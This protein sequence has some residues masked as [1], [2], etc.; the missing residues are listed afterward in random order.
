MTG[1][2]T[3]AL[4][5]TL[6]GLGA[7]SEVSAGGS[8]TDSS[9]ALV[10]P[11][12][13]RPTTVPAVVPAAT[14]TSPDTTVAAPPSPKSAVATTSTSSTTTSVL[15]G[16]DEPSGA[17]T[18]CTHVAYIGDSISLGM[19]S[20]ETLPNATARLDAQMAAIGVVDLR[21][22]ISGGRSIV[23]TLPGQENAHDVA[24]RLRADG[25][26]GCWVIA[27]GTNDAANIA[28]G[29][30]RQQA[31]R[32]TSMMTV[33]GDDPVLWLDAAT[34]TDSGFWATPNMEAWDAGLIAGAA[35]YRNVRVVPWSSFVRREWYQ[36]DGVHLTSAGAAARVQ[37]VVYALAGSFPARRG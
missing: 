29:G 26:R 24:A 6:V 23:E 9:L 28:A 21:A 17:A 32:I 2:R 3:F 19:I 7:C 13:T 27:I 31:E 18:S 11:M 4:V 12:P 30:K 14:P 34:I 5:L 37:Y 20:P 10:G 8:A 35:A 33:L 25:F 1:W 36:A 22:E 15:P 16:A